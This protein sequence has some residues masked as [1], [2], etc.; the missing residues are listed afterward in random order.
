MAP[1]G[2]WARRKS[3]VLDVRHLSS[4]VWQAGRFW[5]VFGCLLGCVVSIWELVLIPD[6]TQ[7]PSLFFLSFPAFSSRGLKGG[8]VEKTSPSTW[9]SSVAWGFY[10]WPERYEKRSCYVLGGFAYE[11]HGM[12]PKF[13]GIAGPWETIGIIGPGPSRELGTS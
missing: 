11:G 4:V 5:M 3:E 13:L 1:S 7:A 10:Q 9:I 8:I 12:D 2:P 6:K